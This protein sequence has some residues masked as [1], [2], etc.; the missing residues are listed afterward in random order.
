MEAVILAAGVGSR[1][2]P[3]TDRRPKCL[4]E[5]GYKSILQWQIEAYRSI[6]VDKVIVV[7]GYRSEQVQSLCSR[8]DLSGLIQVVENREYATTN[9]MFSFALALKEVSGPCFVSNG[10]VV[11]DHEILHLMICDPYPDLIAI[12]RNTYNEESMK[13]IVRDGYI[14]SISKTIG[15]DESYGVSI[16]VYKFGVQTLK[17]LEQSIQRFL[18]RGER[19]LWTEA[20]IND[21]APRCQIRPFDIGTLRWVEIDNHDDLALANRIF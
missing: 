6:G 13:V 3:L 21:V 17:A 2:R 1:L 11:F 4:V 10:D 7:A 12:Q 18:T 14:R 5:V 16:D 19:N 15:A 20:A 9:N 8:L